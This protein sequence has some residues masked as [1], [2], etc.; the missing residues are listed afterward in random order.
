MTRIESRPNKRSSDEYD[1]FIDFVG[2]TDDEHV[3]ALLTD[4]RLHTRDVQV[5]SSR[6]V[7]WFPRRLRDLDQVAAQVLDAGSELQSDHPGFQ[8]LNY[9]NRRRQISD[10][11]EQYRQGDKI[12]R[13]HYSE[14]EVRCWATIYNKL[15]PLAE[16]HACAEYN[17]MLPLLQANCG[18]SVN[19]VPQLQDI[20]EFLKECTGFTLR[21]VTGLLSSRNFLYGLAFRVFFSTQYLRHHSKPLYTPEPDIVHELMGHVPL[22]A[23]QA[24]ADFSQEIGLASLGASD[25]QITEL[26]RCY[27]FSVEFGLCQQN[28]ERKAYGA[29]LLSSFGEMEWAMSSQ[30]TVLPF[31]PFVAAKQE[32]PITTYQPLYFLADS[33]EQMKQQ[34][35][36]FAATFARPFNVRYDPYTQT[37]DVDGNIL[38]DEQ[39]PVPV[40]KPVTATQSTTTTTETMTA[41]MQA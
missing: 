24:F 23:D 28:G 36:G 25:E 1:F 12:P 30:P 7:P 20:S 4:L 3:K 35:Q 34:M 22:F 10:I 14:D 19:N 15:M 31:D 13:I 8:D 32:F 27:W 18:Y 6:R 26:A 5:L 2:T 17:R 39:P 40:K 11:S 16:K 9:R 21:P 38:P 37:I 29:G 33:F 41:S